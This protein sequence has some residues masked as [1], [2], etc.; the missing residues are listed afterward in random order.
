[1]RTL[2]LFTPLDFLLMV[3]VVDAVPPAITGTDSENTGA[4]I[5]TTL[6]VIDQIV[7]RTFVHAPRLRRV[8]PGEPALVAEGRRVEDTPREGETDPHR[9]GQIFCTQGDQDVSEIRLALPETD[10]SVGI[11]PVRRGDSPA[12][13]WT[14]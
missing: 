6:F 2:G 13:S 10:G 11:F 12:P 8:L 14:G 3:L 5:V 4:I 9:R 1:L 7:D